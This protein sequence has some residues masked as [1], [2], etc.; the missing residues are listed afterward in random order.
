[1]INDA[2]L[3][4]GNF[5]ERI[6]PVSRGPSITYLSPF[7]RSLHSYLIWSGALWG[8]IKCVLWWK[9]HWLESLNLSFRPRCFVVVLV[10]RGSPVVR[11][12]GAEQRR[13]D[14]ANIGHSIV[15]LTESVWLSCWRSPWTVCVDLHSRQPSG[16]LYQSSCSGKRQGD[17]CAPEPVALA[18]ANVDCGAF[19]P[20]NFEEALWTSTSGAQTPS[21]LSSNLEWPHFPSVRGG[22]WNF[23]EFRFSHSG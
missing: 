22:F 14:K 1:M 5:K 13:T 17:F 18:W 20:F 16:W 4:L 7:V 21:T 3:L 8:I 19:P 10:N 2:K 23:K 15:M 6:L 12:N 9:S 11:G